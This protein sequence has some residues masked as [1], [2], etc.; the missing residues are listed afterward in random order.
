MCDC[1][2][3]GACED[4]RRGASVEQCQRG[5]ARVGLENC[6]IA[7]LSSFE[8]E[9]GPSFQVGKVSQDIATPP[10]GLLWQLLGRC[11]GRW[12]D[13]DCGFCP[14]VATTATATPD[15]TLDSSGGKVDHSCAENEWHKN[16]H[17][18]NAAED[19]R[20]KPIPRPQQQTVLAFTLSAS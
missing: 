5:A 12:R 16:Q 7:F 17:H 18:C 3:V 8:P 9:F 1:S 14:A 15:N 13:R 6:R 4:G 19:G 2:A 20:K 10:P 11:T